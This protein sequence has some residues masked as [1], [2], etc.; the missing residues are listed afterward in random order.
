MLLT[1]APALGA[2]DAV[3]LANGIKIGEVRSN[4]AI[5]WARVT[6]N[7]TRN[8]EGPT[9]SRM[10]RGRRDHTLAQQLPEG[11][12]LEQMQF[13]VPG[14]PGEVRVVFGQVGGTLSRSTPWQK[15]EAKDD[16]TRQFRLEGLEPATRYELRVEVRPVGG[17]EATSQMTGSFTTAAAAGNPQEVTF[18]VVTGQRYDTIDSQK[19]GN[20][21]YVSM[22][23]L[24]PE[25]FVHTGDIVYYDKDFPFAT[26]VAS[27]RFKWHRMYSYPNHME[28]HRRVPS[29][30]IKDDHDTLRNDCWPGQTYG[31]LTWQQGLALFREQVPMGDKTYRT[32][33]WGKDLQI[34][35]VEGRDFR[36]PNRTPDGPDKTLWGKEQKQWFFRTVQ[37]SD[38]TFKI[39]IS[40]TPLVGPDRSGK[41]D[42]HANKNFSHEG[43]ELRKFIGQQKNMY[44]ACGDRHWQYASVDP[45]T[46]VEEFCSGP[47]TKKHSGG[48]SEKN[49]DPKMHKYL[50]IIGGFLSVTVERRDAKPTAI[51]R[52]H[53]VDGSV[54]NEI[55]KPAK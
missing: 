38:A 28:F 2:G 30:F 51:F 22:L 13:E 11:A 20:E 46:G 5:V 35:L 55:I 45:E 42:N 41:N 52:H 49:R 37:E 7:P 53:Q 16:Y 48:F 14:A 17:S 36:S 9:F 44:V 15:A 27:A 43:N 31:D 1:M 10:P 54:A 4:S 29:Y 3:H 23:K 32:V 24:D 34:W 19:T 47:T 33:R 26:D 50:N 21:I 40:A 12:A 18:T 6:K 39:L 25:F 8:E